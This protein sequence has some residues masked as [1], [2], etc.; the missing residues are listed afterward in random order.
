[1]NLLLNVSI[2]GLSPWVAINAP[3]WRQTLRATLTRHRRPSARPHDVLA[4]LQGEGPHQQHRP[5]AAEAEASGPAGAQ[6]R[7]PQDASRFLQRPLNQRW[8]VCSRPRCWC[9][10]A[11]R[12][13]EHGRHLAEALRHLTRSRPVPRHRPHLLTRRRHLQQVTAR[14]GCSSGPRTARGRVGPGDGRSSSWEGQ[15]PPSD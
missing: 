13:E 3:G 1:M 7:Q 5:L 8:E 11:L 9:R 4:K 6:H 12:E 15:G 2:P 10:G 14:T